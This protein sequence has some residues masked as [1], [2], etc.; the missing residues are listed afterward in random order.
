M[1]AKMG[2]R[3]SSRSIAYSLSTRESS[4][5]V[6]LGWSD[7]SPDHRGDAEH[8]QQIQTTDMDLDLTPAGNHCTKSTAT[9]LLEAVAAVMGG[10]ERSRQEEEAAFAA[11]REA[12]DGHEKGDG[13]HLAAAHLH[14]SYSGG[15]H[16]WARSHTTS[17]LQLYPDPHHVGASTET[18]GLGLHLCSPATG[19]PPTTGEGAE[20]PEWNRRS[21]PRLGAGKRPRSPSA[22]WTVAS[23]PDGIPASTTT[24]SFAAGSSAVMA[25]AGASRISSLSA[26][27]GEG[28]QMIV[29]AQ[30][31]QQQ[32]VQQQQQGPF[33]SAWPWSC[34]PAE[35]MHPHS[36]PLSLP[37]MHSAHF[38]QQAMAT[39]PDAF[40]Q[41]ESPSLSMAGVQHDLSSISMFP[42]VSAP[43]TFASI[44]PTSIAVPQFDLTHHFSSAEA[45]APAI[46]FNGA[47]PMNVPA[48]DVLSTPTGR[49]RCSTV[50]QSLLEG[51]N[52]ASEMG[53][54]QLE[55]KQ[56][57]TSKEQPRAQAL[58][59]SKANPPAAAAVSPSATDPFSFELL[60]G[61]SHAVRA[62]AKGD[63]HMA[64]DDEGSKPFS[65]TPEF[66]GLN[67]TTAEETDGSHDSPSSVQQ[68]SGR[69]SD[70]LDRKEMDGVSSCDDDCDDEDEGEDEE[71]AGP[72]VNN[73]LPECLTVNIGI[74]GSGD[75]TKFSQFSDA[76]VAGSL[77]SLTSEIS[78]DPNAV[79]TSPA[80]AEDD[81]DELREMV[82]PSHQG[83]KPA[84]KAKRVSRKQLDA[85][86]PEERE[87]FIA[88]KKEAC[89]ERRRMTH[90]VVERRRR[91]H[92]NECI[93][94]LATL[95]PES[96]LVEAIA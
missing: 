12:P 38:L 21:I 26:S 16:R 94:E 59:R 80:V 11:P 23:L 1:V 79:L 85:M 35:Q 55:E 52:K 24:V 10:T 48:L 3:P 20:G 89:R 92:I 39:S 73:T 22:P 88:A 83:S 70:E 2:K 40:P 36:T 62:A 14:T 57:L 63:E 60:I 41:F 6:Q 87:K 77:A 74:N 78:E 37:A 64:T 65:S 84:V 67:L 19:P 15:T 69:H 8:V 96:M 4:Q 66:A 9:K 71:E 76:K 34:Q 51:A 49:S 91:D 31:S 95:L 93:S 90:N 13:G 45:A 27:Q 72:D 56:R 53:S 5:S 32:Q 18:T 17:G 54:L 25:D 43:F 46:H 75:A 42:H 68:L 44:V 86:T 50:G 28:M 81:W 30:V 58:P 33:A 29:M 82:E 7:E 47:P 61:R